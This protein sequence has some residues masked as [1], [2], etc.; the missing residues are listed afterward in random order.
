MRRGRGFAERLDYVGHFSGLKWVF[1]E[2]PVLRDV[3]FGNGVGHRL[4]D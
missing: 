4:A 1:G 3:G 2:R